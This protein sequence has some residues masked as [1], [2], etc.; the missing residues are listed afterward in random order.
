M[1]ECCMNCIYCKPFHHVIYQP[2]REF[3]K[4]CCIVLANEPDGFVQQV[5]WNDMCEMFTPKEDKTD[6]K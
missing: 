6:E 5:M 1:T 2:Y 4:D 3:V